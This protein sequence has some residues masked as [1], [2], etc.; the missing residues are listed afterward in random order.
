M[1]VATTQSRHDSPIAPN[2]LA[3]RF[4][5]TAPNRGRDLT[6]LRALRASRTWRSSDSTPGAARVG[7]P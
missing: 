1:F 6:Y 7:C 4:D 2:R 5:V 3:R